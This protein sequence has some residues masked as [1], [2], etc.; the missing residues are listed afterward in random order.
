MRAKARANQARMALNRW[1][2]ASVRTSSTCAKANSGR[3]GIDPEVRATRGGD[4]TVVGCRWAACNT[5]SAPVWSPNP[6]AR[7]QAR[8]A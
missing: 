5:A 3:P 8:W 1:A 7:F 6:W 2:L 4:V